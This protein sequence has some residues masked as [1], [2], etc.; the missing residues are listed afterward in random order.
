MLQISW[1]KAT[2]R[3]VVVD[4]CKIP[5]GGGT[6]QGNKERECIVGMTDM[7][8]HP[9]A[10]APC[11]QNTPTGAES[12]KKGIVKAQTEHAWY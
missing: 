11:N 7:G 12:R 10:G 9:D 5:L 8:C 1:R 4:R 2:D 6:D 3:V